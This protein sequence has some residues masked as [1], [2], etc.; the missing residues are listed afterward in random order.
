[1]HHIVDENSAN[2]SIQLDLIADFAQRVDFGI[3]GE[4]TLVIDEPQPLGANTG[5]SPTRVLSAALASC[6]GASLLFCLKKSHVSV[7]GLHTQAS[8]TMKRNEHGRLRVERIDVRLEPV[9]PL[10]QQSRMARCLEVFEDYCVV[11]AS[12]RPAITVNV[13]VHPVAPT[14][15][16]S[17]QVAPP[18]GDVPTLSQTSSAMINTPAHDSLTS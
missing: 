8:V 13:S 1:M 15:F 6:L 16:Q 2:D 18:V 14:E 12:V 3:A 10:E 9:V 7:H 4:S 5:P 17:E 11:T